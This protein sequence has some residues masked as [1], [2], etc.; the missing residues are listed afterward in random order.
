[1]ERAGK[2]ILARAIVLYI[3][4]DWAEYAHT[5]GFPTWAAKWFPCIFCNCNKLNML[6]LQSV[7]MASLPW[8][9]H[10]PSDYYEACRNCEV[11]VIVPDQRGIMDIRKELEWDK[12]QNGFRG[13]ALMGDVPKYNLIKGD[14][15]EPSKMLIDIT[16]FDNISVFPTILHFWRTTKETITLHR[17]PLFDDP[18]VDI[19]GEELGINP[20]TT[21]TVDPLHDIHL[22]VLAKFIVWCLWTFLIADIYDVMKPTEDERY[23]VGIQRLRADLWQWYNVMRKQKKDGK[24]RHTSELQTLTL[25]MIGTK[26][27]PKLRA[28]AG[29]TKDLLGFVVHMLE[30]H[31]EKLKDHNGKDLLEAGKS[32]SI[33]MDIMNNHGRVLPHEALQELCNILNASACSIDH[34][35]IGSSCM[36]TLCY[37]YAP[38]VVCRHAF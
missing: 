20:Y 29:Q 27:D 25:K 31:M 32:I 9:E 1:V 10:E 36:G 4:G 17:N 8:D 34:L 23:R 22:G 6:A 24:P 3:K 2:K 11:V 19:E 21:M 16:D 26:A 13:R 33:V 7:S 38:S 12:R 5:F 14:R 18:D 30:T 28:K 37:P 15:L 35:P